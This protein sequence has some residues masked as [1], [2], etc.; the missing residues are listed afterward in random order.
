MPIPVINYS[1]QQA[2]QFEPK[3]IDVF[4]SLGRG[5]NLGLSVRDRI[6]ALKQQRLANELS[7]LK[8]KFAP[9]QMENEVQHGSLSNA[10]S[11]L[12]LQYQPSIYE[13][14]LQTGNLGNQLT[15]LRMQA[16][17]NEMSTPKP[18]STD[19]GKKINEFERIKNQFGE[20]SPQAQLFN[21]YVTQSVGGQT[22]FQDPFAKA[23]QDRD[24]IVQTYGEDNDRVKQFDQY[25]S[26]RFKLN[27]Q[28]SA[29]QPQVLLDP[30]SGAPLINVSGTKGTGARM[31]GGTYL[32]PQTSEIF[33]FQTPAVKSRDLKTIAGAENVKAY[34]NSIKELAP[35]IPL[36]TSAW[37]KGKLRG[38][39]LSNAIL[40]TSFSSPSDVAELDAS[41]KSFSEGFVNQF[42]LNATNENINKAESII[43]PKFGE[44]TDLY[45]KRVEKQ[46]K[47][48]GKIQQRAQ[49]RVAG[50]Q[51][52]GYL[53]GEQ[54]KGKPI[55]QTTFQ[56]LMGNAS[57]NTLSTFSQLMNMENQSQ[58]IN[59]IGKIKNNPAGK[60][61]LSSQ[62]SL[63][64]NPG[65][66][67]FR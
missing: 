22:P 9:Q 45:L 66:G 33:G 40:G 28:N 56:A 30:N 27:G 18:F 12:Q 31:G 59:S 36:M 16:L 3:N 37:G 14:N 42:G 23:Q 65:T 60:D 24:R 67:D 61:N 39:S 29:N 38:A 5:M 10:L 2:Q 6:E 64:Y 49:S 44:N 34:V 58:P 55:D 11:Q 35:A 25:L 46:L 20:N 15:S 1:A 13:Q 32:N 21:Q 53:G 50:G 54:N 26:E 63:N 4:G 51:F 47:E 52:I 48:F 7:T 19:L 62:K 17:R 43:A 57:P 41:I 8:N